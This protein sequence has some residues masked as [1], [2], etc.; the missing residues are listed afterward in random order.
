LRAFGKDDKCFSFYIFIMSLIHPPLLSPVMPA[1][2]WRSSSCVCRITDGA[3]ELIAGDVCLITDGAAKLLA[4]G[5]C[6]C[7]CGNGG[8]L[9]GVVCRTEDGIDGLLGRLSDL[10]L[11]VD[12]ER[13]V[14]WAG[15]GRRGEEGVLGVELVLVVA[16]GAVSEAGIEAVLVAEVGFPASR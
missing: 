9:T 12:E 10:S 2:F 8:L 5:V 1:V 4:V 3:A 15:T 13:L 14:L 16:E 6:L 11:A 7:K